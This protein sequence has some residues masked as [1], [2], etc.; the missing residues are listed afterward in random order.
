MP[1]F[2]AY[3]DNRARARDRDETPARTGDARANG[4]FDGSC[5]RVTLRTQLIREAPDIWAGAEAESWHARGGEGRIPKSICKRARRAA[6]SLYCFAHGDSRSGSRPPCALAVA[7]PVPQARASGRLDEGESEAQGK[8]RVAG[9]KQN[10]R[11]LTKPF[12]RSSTPT[13]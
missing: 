13:A 8:E 6:P 10:E 5:S 11:N 12:T 7:P 9:T 4:G 3:R 1:G 2:T